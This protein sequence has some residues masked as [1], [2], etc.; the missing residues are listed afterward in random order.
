MN[1]LAGGAGPMLQL[2]IVDNILGNDCGEWGES[3]ISSFTSHVFGGTP[4]PGF[5]RV[6]TCRPGRTPKYNI[7][8]IDLSRN[9]SYQGKEREAHVIAA[10]GSF[11]LKTCKRHRRRSVGTAGARRGDRAG[12]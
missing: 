11:R 12:I 10:G 2:S 1:R 8:R 6:R 9:H 4:F 3:F 5:Q 7:G